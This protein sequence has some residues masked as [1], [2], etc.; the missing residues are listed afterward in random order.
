[1]AGERHEQIAKLP[2]EN[3]R[4]HIQEDRVHPCNHEGVGPDFFPQGEEII[5]PCFGRIF[6]RNMSYAALRSKLGSSSAV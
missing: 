6:Q 3:A 2:G 5:L 4:R 1:M